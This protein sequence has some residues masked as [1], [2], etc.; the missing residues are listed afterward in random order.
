MAVIVR[1]SR[2]FC[3]IC[4]KVV[5]PATEVQLLGD[6]AEVLTS[7]ERVFPLAFFDIM[8]H[9]T[10]HLVEELFICGPAHTHWMYLYER[11]F[12]GLK[13]FVHNLAKP[14]GSMA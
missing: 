4:A 5:D 10:V 1:L 7:L 2:L 13:S 14:K 11:Y 3:W 9:L 12:K 6:A 8:V